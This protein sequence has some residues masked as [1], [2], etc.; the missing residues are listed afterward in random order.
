MKK[1][2]NIF[3]LLILSLSLTGCFEQ[4]QFSI[5]LQP[6]LFQGV[7]TIN[8]NL[9]INLEFSNISTMEYVKTNQN[10]IKDLSTVSAEYHVNL[11]L[12]KENHNYII[13]FE[14]A[15]SINYNKINS[16]EL[17]RKRY[18]PLKITKMLFKLIDNDSDAIVDEFEV[19]YQLDG[20]KDIA[21][22]KLISKSSRGNTHGNYYYN[23]HLTYDENIVFLDE[24]KETFLAGTKLNYRISKIEGYKVVMYVNDELYEEKI[25]SL[26]TY[27]D[28][29]YVPGYS[30]VNIEFKAVKIE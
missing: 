15:E 24:P 27:M 29:N 23:C 18:D 28:F 8:S 13:E 20:I 16:Y 4:K 6:A 14:H 7:S 5:A 9:K 25:P 19:S 1:I 2:F 21:N 10:K 17:Y 22:L 30:D 3:L 26:M 11:V 12:S